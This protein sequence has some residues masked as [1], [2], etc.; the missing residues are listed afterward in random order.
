MP[1]TPLVNQLPPINL[2]SFILEELEFVFRKIKN[3]RAPGPDTIPSEFW[4]WTSPTFKDHI[5]SLRD[6]CF[7]GASSPDEW[8]ETHL[9]AILKTPQ[10][11]ISSRNLLDQLLS[12]MQSTKYTHPYYK[13]D[14]LSVLTAHS[15]L[16]NIDSDHKKS[17]AQPIFVFRQILDLHE[18]HQGLVKSF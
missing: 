5:L 1:R 12:S 8:N 2:N 16:H 10:K 7:L 3:R 15:V 11:K 17:T 13:Q 18:G 6:I 9:V 14:S 4:K